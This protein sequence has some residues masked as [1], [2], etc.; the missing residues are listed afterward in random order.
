MNENNGKIKILADYIKEE[1]K[2]FLIYWQKEDLDI[3]NYIIDNIK[4]NLRDYQKGSIEN[5]LIMKNS[6]DAVNNSSLKWNNLSS[7]KEQINDYSNNHY[8]FHMATGS[9][10]TLIIA[11]TILHMYKLWYKKFIFFNNSVNIVNKTKFNLLPQLRN[12]KCEFNEKIVIDWKEVKIKEVDVFSTYS[13]DIEI[14]FTTIQGLHE[15]IQKNK[16]NNINLDILS[17]FNICMLADEA[18]HYQK[19]TKLKDLTKKEKA[20]ITFN[21][22]NWEKTINLILN[23]V[24]KT[25][26]KKNNILFEYSATMDLEWEFLEKYI[27][28]IIYDYPLKNFREDWYSKDVSLIQIPDNKEKIITS[29]IISCYRWYLAKQYDSIKHLIPRIFFKCTWEIEELLEVKKKT[30]QEIE[31]LSR[32]D[33]LNIINKH[34]K[35]NGKNIFNFIQ[36]DIVKKWQLDNFLNNIKKYYNKNTAIHIHSDEKEIEKTKKRI[37]L[38]NIDNNQDI[39][40]I[41]AID[42]LNEGWD[43]LSL[44]DIVK[45]DKEG[46]WQDATTSERQLIGRWMRLFPYDWKDELWNDCNKYKRKFDRNIEDKLRILEE[47]YFYTANENN[48]ITNLKKD[49]IKDGAMAD[50]KEELTKVEVQQLNEN[51]NFLLQ[52]AEKLKIFSNEKVPYYNDNNKENK[53][54][55]YILKG[56]IVKDYSI[57]RIEL[58]DNNLEL[59]EKESE[60]MFF[61]D[62]LCWKQNNIF[63]L[64]KVIKSLDFFSYNNIS[65]YIK[66]EK[67]YDLTEDLIELSKKYTLS[68]IEKTIDKLSYEEKKNLILIFLINVSKTLEKEINKT[69]GTKDFNKEI[70]INNLF[71][72]YYKRKDYVDGFNKKIEWKDAYWKDILFEIPI[73]NKKSFYYNLLSWD[74]LLEINFISEI[75]RSIITSNKE[76]DYLII[77]NEVGYKIYNNDQNSEYSGVGFEPDFIILKRKKDSNLIKILIL[78]VK[79]KELKDEDSQKWKEKLLK[80]INIDKIVGDFH[81]IV[82]WLP[83]FTEEDRQEYKQKTEKKKY[84]GWWIVITDFLQKIVDA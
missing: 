8:L 30:L 60:N 76:I 35:N 12:N 33:L 74:S 63:I 64:E 62:F 75:D 19:E 2:K 4:Y 69:I 77:R 78:E 52:I 48:Y 83:F 55:K 16:E 24:N 29:I 61:Y 25:T 39:R 23:L 79:W 53:L 37:L 22:R 20:E 81:Y 57:D 9:G 10:K 34:T 49:L 13:D 80:E 43:V 54:S 5:L 11:A 1:K 65:K 45:L 56:E 67:D 18:H 38:N 71:V 17:K 36:E 42:I 44:F 6:K 66:I 26:N 31:E 27:N 70:D 32:E 59:N 58:T 46:K 28:K 73:R 15:K 50:E 7:V 40:M 51:Q 14:I 47:L 72:P 68:L 41:F 84:T 3:P 21:N 82:R